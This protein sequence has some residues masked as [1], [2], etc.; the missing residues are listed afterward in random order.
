M[1]KSGEW[2]R[3]CR[4]LVGCAGNSFV[5]SYSTQRFSDQNGFQEGGGM[6][7]ERSQRGSRVARYAHLP[8]YSFGQIEGLKNSHERS[9]TCS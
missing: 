3:R 8:I 2:N 4:S 1:D 9:V 7:R 5:S 6:L